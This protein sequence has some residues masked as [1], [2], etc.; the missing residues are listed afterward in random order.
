MMFETDLRFLTLLQ[1]YS[2]KYNIKHYYIIVVGGL[3]GFL[4]TASICKC[5]AATESSHRVFAMLKVLGVEVSVT[6]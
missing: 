1:Y 3:L 6:F 4:G 5:S 2:K